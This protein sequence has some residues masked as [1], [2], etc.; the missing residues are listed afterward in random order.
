[1]LFG[2]D[3]MLL[4][5]LAMGARG[6]VGTTYGYAAPLYRRIIAAFESGDL[7]AARDLQSK[8]VEMIA[9][10]RQFGGLSA[11]KAM[12]RMIG[13]DLGPCRPPLVD[14]TGHRYDELRAALEQVGFFQWCN[15]AGKRE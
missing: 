9:L 15:T 8:S 10:M 5:G 14:L 2:R 13:L 12:M 11:S 3:E 7:P 1:M 4:A 6:G